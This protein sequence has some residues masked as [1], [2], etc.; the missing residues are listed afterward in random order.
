MAA[1]KPRAYAVAAYFG[2]DTNGFMA[3]LPWI[4]YEPEQAAGAV[5][6]HIINEMGA[7]LPLTNVKATE[8][9]RAWLEK[10]L[11]VIDEADAAAEGEKA[12]DD[13]LRSK[14]IWPGGGTA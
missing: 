14:L 4:A 11:R 7:S 10:A 6:A 1:P 13:A 12:W 9:P 5:V 8:L 2:D 3:C